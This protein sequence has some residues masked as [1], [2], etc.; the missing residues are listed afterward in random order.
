MHV[1]VLLHETID[2]LDIQH[3][4]VVV[5]ATLGGGGHAVAAAKRISDGVFIG[6]D[7]DRNAVERVKIRFAEAGVTCRHVLV[8]ENFRHLDRVLALAG[9]REAH[10]IFFDIGLS[11]YQLETEYGE[12]GRGFSFER[13]EPLRMTF[14]V[15]PEESGEYRLTA[16]EIVNTWDESSIADVLYHYGEERFA[17]RIAAAI[18]R[19]R[20]ESPIQTTK[21]LVTIVEQAIPKANRRRHHPATKTF[22]ALRVTVNDEIGALRQALPLAFNHLAHGGRMAAISFHSIE[23]RVIKQYMRTLAADGLASVLT[24]KPIV[25]SSDEV[26]RNPRSRSAKL[27]LLLK[28]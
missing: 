13:D 2:G 24:K 15:E 17:R 4:D 23:D 3:A 9:V 14:S 22:Q 26:A 21:Q 28:R 19:A 5:D 11:S 8:V 16:E 10:K 25:P 1:P 7:A 6:I 18:M 12:A 27:R 20:S